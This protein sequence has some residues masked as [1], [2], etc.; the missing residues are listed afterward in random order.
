MNLRRS[1]IAMAL[2]RCNDFEERDTQQCDAEQVKSI[3]QD[4]RPTWMACEDTTARCIDGGMHQ[5]SL[6]GVVNPLADADKHQSKAEQQRVGVG[7]ALDLNRQ[8]HDGAR[9]TKCHKKVVPVLDLEPGIRFVAHGD[10]PL[11]DGR[12]LAHGEAA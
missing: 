7:N 3:P 8:A 9:C 2:S 10:L 6:E 5:P 4:A 1:L 11:N 12:I